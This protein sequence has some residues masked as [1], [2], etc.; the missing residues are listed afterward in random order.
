MKTTDIIY[1]KE[2]EKILSAASA[3]GEQLN[4]PVYL[5][6]GYIRD[7]FLNKNRVDIDIMVGNNVFEFSKILSKKLN[8][9][10]TVN[11]EKFQTSRIPYK[12]CDI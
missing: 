10:T 11:F 2:H 6:G 4:I 3:I 5:V 8:I 1:S 9:N 12:N 7:A